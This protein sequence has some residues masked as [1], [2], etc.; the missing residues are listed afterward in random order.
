MKTTQPRRFVASAALPG[1]GLPHD[2]ASR[3]AAR[4]AF[5]E[6]KHAFTAAVA[7]VEGRQGD[8]LRMQIRAAEDPLDLWLLRAP[9]MDALAARDDSTRAWRQELRRSLS[10]LFPDS[11]HASGFAPLVAA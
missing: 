8:W 10:G 5:V 4:R 7:R 3:I 2:R 11:E 1:A 6:L 9:V